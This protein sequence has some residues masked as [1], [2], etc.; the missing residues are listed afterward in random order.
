MSE[1]GNY[2]LC[3]GRMTNIHLLKHDLKKQK[4]EKQSSPRFNYALNDVLRRYGF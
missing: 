3:L 1:N 4:R 2:L